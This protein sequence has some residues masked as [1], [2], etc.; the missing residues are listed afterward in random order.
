MKMT[1]QAI[2]ALYWA[3]SQEALAAT[4]EKYGSYCRAI[5]CN[6]LA[7]R[8]DADECV[9]D[10]YWNAWRS[11]P[12]QRPSRLRIYLGRITRNLSLDRFK[13]CSAR[14][15]GGSQADLALDELEECI[16]SPD[17]VEQ[18]AD[19]QALTELLEQFLSEQ[20]RQKRGIFIRRYWY[21]DPIRDI[22]R[23]YTMS[24]SK[25]ASILFRMR[26]ELRVRLE[27][28]GFSTGRVNP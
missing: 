23:A 3:R 11:M 25:A 26:A 17:G 14:K 4:A 20:P 1:D 2:V 27:Q 7:S 18:A 22:A 12:P 13:R 15:R 19:A 16:S 9:N 5:A 8:E 28:E 10:T 24:E 6:I 21:L